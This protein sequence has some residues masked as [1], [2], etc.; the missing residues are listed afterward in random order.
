MTICISD[1]LA[2]RGTRPRGRPDPDSH[3]LVDGE[4]VRWETA[5]GGVY[6]FEIPAGSR[7]VSI[8]SRI[9]TPAEL[10]AASRNPPPRRRD[11]AAGAARPGSAD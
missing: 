2:R 6:R 7:D 10:V 3:L 4:I 9:G 1:A 5:S 11:R 8:A